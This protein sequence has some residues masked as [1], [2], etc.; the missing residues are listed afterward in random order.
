MPY[1]TVCISGMSIKKIFNKAALIA[2][3]ILLF[4]VSDC[5]LSPK[6]GR[7][8]YH[9]KI[10]PCTPGENQNSIECENWKK[11]FPKE[12]K[13]YQKRQDNVKSK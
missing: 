11:Q 8:V 3:L 5:S 2:V 6:I 4:T 1:F 12:Y 9:D 7:A 13:R 10:N